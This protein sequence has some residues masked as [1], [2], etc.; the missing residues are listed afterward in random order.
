MYFDGVK[1]FMLHKK[2][3]PE[4]QYEFGIIFMKNNHFSEIYTNDQ[5]VFEKWTRLLGNKCILTTFHEDF[6]VKK[7]IGKGSFAKVYLAT[8]KSSARDYAIKAF[9][10][11]F[12]LSQIKGP[13]NF[14]KINI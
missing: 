13:V 4:M 12:L 6:E 10:K 9:S 2:I 7:M 1:L 8:K 3:N 11:E 5:E 14:I